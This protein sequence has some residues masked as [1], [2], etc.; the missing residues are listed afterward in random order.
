MRSSLLLLVLWSGAVL[1]H[2]WTPTYPPLQRSFMEGIVKAEMVLF[3]KRE[4]VE[5]FEI[6]VTDKDFNSLPFASSQRIYKVKYLERRTIK[7]FLK[8]DLLHRTVYICSKSRFL[9]QN[10]SKNMVSSRICSKIR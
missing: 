6:E 8:E 5:Y 3:N 10:V 7:V 4:D 1:G 9:K 2:S